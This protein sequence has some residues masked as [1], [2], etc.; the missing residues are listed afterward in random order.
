[1][2]FSDPLLISAGAEAD[3]VRIKLLKSYFLT[4]NAELAKKYQERSLAT[5]SEDEKYLVIESDIP[6]QVKNEADMIMLEDAM[7]SAIEAF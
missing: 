1:M 3:T 4:N 6:R 7:S 5:L 2:N